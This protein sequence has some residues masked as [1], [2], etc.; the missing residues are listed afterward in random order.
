MP[1]CLRCRVL[2]SNATK[3]CGQ[4]GYVMDAS[5]SV[6]DLYSSDQDMQSPD[7]NAGLS[8]N[9]YELIDQ[10]Q[11]RPL[12]DDSGRS[13]M[14][15][16]HE[17]ISPPG[18]E[19]QIHLHGSEQMHASHQQP[20]QIH[21]PHQQPSQGHLYEPPQI[22]ASHQQPEQIHASHQQPEQIHA[23]HQQP[24][25]IHASHQQ[26]EQIHASHQQPEQ[27]H[28]SHQ[29]PQQI[30]ASHQQ[31][32]QVHASHQQ[33][34]QIHAPH[35]QPSQVHLYEPPQMH[36]SHQQPGQIHA[37]HQQPGQVHA[38]HQQPQQI[39]ASHQQPGQIHT[40]HQQPQQI[41]AS[42]QQPRQI[43]AL[44]QQPHLKTHLTHTKAANKGCRPSCLTMV[45][46]IGALIAIIT[47]TVFVAYTHPFDHHEPSP[48][49]ALAGKALLGQAITL[50]G[51]DFPP[52]SRVMVT[53]DNLSLV[54]MDHSTPP[55]GMRMMSGPLLALGSPPAGNWVTVGRDG[56]FAITIHISQHW[57]TGSV[58]SL[59]VYGQDSKFITS[60][61]FK[62]V[63]G[64]PGPSLVPCTAAAS[65]TMMNLGPVAEGDS[66]AVSMPFQLC[67]SG[68]GTLDWTSSWDQQQAPWLQVDQNGHLSAP[69]PQQIQVR[70]S[71]QGLK[72]GSY[73]ADI[74]FKSLPSDTKVVLAVTFLV[75][76]RDTPPCIQANQP[77][78]S[79]TGQLGQGGLV[80]QKVVIQ[81]GSGCGAGSWSASS[82]A[83]WL[84]VNPA[85]G[86]ID[87]GGSAAVNVRASLTGLNA[88]QYTGHITFN[89]GLATTTVNVTVQLPPPCL[90]VNPSTLTF[91]VTQGN[92]PS[93]Q[94]LTIKN[95][96]QCSAG[97]WSASSDASWLQVSQSSGQIGI[98]SDMAVSI[99]VASSSLSAGSYTGHVTFRAGSSTATVTAN[100]NV[101]PKPCISA[102]PT[103]LT[104]SGTAS[105]AG[106]DPAPQSVTISTCAQRAGTVSA[107]V[108]S[109]SANWLHVSGGGSISANGQLTFTVSA[110]ATSAGLASGRYTGVIT[111]VITTSDGVSSQ[112]TVSVDL[113]VRP[114]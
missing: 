55:P 46:G 6:N 112:T 31:P 5:T 73:T 50:Q 106:P 57:N 65:Q 47:A 77:A 60:I 83:S 45:A 96:N 84:S 22:H 43:H 52:G 21:A 30:H 70:A 28:A 49:L 110:S 109:A 51:S 19:G 9:S 17:Y 23:S 36:A 74:T 53:L 107:S 75:Q 63:S 26:P 91:S 94:G 4:C 24:E 89:P 76:A 8:R 42:H 103:A 27:I 105:R 71:A 39:H 29:Q 54:D 58:H 67:T 79:F 10:I 69:Q 16:R 37:S 56:T 99:G 87:L 93:N 98:G 12:L 78:L 72:A 41:H 33:P 59:R 62:A 85:S 34:Q 108:N 114:T 68:S 104:F 102:Q 38:S 13:G 18:A 11:T 86:S 61:D 66:Q 7:D 32:G 1:R 80:P 3:I 111:F 88:G 25:Q 44:H 95:G 35:Q 101:L 15:D 48:T 100:V 82:D 97:S 113:S 20:G 81:N 64:I 40:L 2:L 90:S 14:Y 92:V